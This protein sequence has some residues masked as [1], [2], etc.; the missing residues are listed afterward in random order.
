MR[1]LQLLLGQHLRSPAW[2]TQGPAVSA[3]LAGLSSRLC[4]SHGCSRRGAGAPRPGFSDH[5]PERRQKSEHMSHPLPK[6]PTS[7]TSKLRV[8][9]TQVGAQ[10]R[11]TAARL[12]AVGQREAVA[13]PPARACRGQLDCWTDTPTSTLPAPSQASMAGRGGA[14]AA[15]DKPL[16]P[17]RTGAGRLLE[18]ALARGPPQCH[19][20][21][22]VASRENSRRQTQSPGVPLS[23][24]SAPPLTM[25]TTLLPEAPSHRDVGTTGQTW[26]RPAPK[27]I[28]QGSGYGLE[29]AGINRGG[30]AGLHSR[31]PI[32]PWGPEAQGWSWCDVSAPQP[33][34]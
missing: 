2:L 21:E 9:P 1:H 4:A 31:V 33:S 3:V 12:R 16:G 23:L 10:P 24:C 18:L 27:P 17:L 22:P 15:E 32:S 20:L 19:S 26:R 7:F 13:C 30:G 6:G 11:R 5:T 14:G 25:V 34:G 29:L 8:H 28:V